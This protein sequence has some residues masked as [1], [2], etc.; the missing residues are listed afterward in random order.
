MDPNGEF[1]PL[2]KGFKDIFHHFSEKLM[3]KSPQKRIFPIGHGVKLFGNF[4]SFIR[5]KLTN[6]TANNEAVHFN[7][8]KMFDNLPNKRITGE[9][10]GEM[11]DEDEE[12]QKIQLNHFRDRVRKMVVAHGKLLPFPKM[13]REAQ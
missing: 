12:V 4:L 3:G 2:I 7:R 13:F 6:P 8:M 9:G 11:K 5:N 1:S 10:D